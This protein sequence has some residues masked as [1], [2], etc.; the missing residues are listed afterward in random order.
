MKITWKEHL[1]YINDSHVYVIKYITPYGK[2]EMTV[3]KSFWEKY[4]RKFNK[5]MK[6]AIIISLEEIEIK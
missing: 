5:A 3:K 1:L 4:Q 2:G 6:D